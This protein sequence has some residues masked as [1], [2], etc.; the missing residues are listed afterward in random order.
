MADT[1]PPHALSRTERLLFIGSF[2]A[3]AACLLAPAWVANDDPWPG[4]GALLMGPIG[5]P[6]GYVAWLA[7]PLLWYAWFATARGLHSRAV[8]SAI[9]AI[10]LALSFLLHQTIPVGSSG[11]FAFSIRYGFGLWLISMALAEHASYLAF[12]RQLRLP[13]DPTS[14]KTN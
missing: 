7:N 1:T 4:W 6:L 12:C 10:V 5:V 14:A 13:L 2:L 11:E 9:F 3:Y 8:V